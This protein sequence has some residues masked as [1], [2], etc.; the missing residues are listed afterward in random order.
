VGKRYHLDQLAVIST[1]LKG[2]PSVRTEVVAGLVGDD[3]KA[4]D[5]SEHELHKIDDIDLK[6][7]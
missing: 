5:R 7:V 2:T 1:L 4:I 3:M 6:N